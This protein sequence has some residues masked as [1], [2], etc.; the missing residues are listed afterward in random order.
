[1]SSQ[2]WRRVTGSTPLVGSSRKTMVGR[3][4]RATEKASFWRQPRGSALTRVSAA[5]SSFRRASMAPM[6]SRISASV[7]P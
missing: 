5:A 6:R 7:R 3:C 4:R 2:N 1:M